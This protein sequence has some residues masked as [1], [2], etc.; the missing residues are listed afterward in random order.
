MVRTRRKANAILKDKE[1]D[2]VMP[3]M[4]V[5]FS[6][7][8]I[9]GV[10]SKSVNIPV[11]PNMK[12]KL[13]PAHPF[14]LNNVGKSGSGKTNV[15]IYML[16]TP[17][18]WRDYFQRVYLFGH[19]VKTDGMYQHL[20]VP[21]KNVFTSDMVD[22][23]DDVISKLEKE[24]KDKGPQHMKRTLIIFEDVSSN[25]DLLRSK[26]FTKC[27][28]QGRHLNMSVIANSHKYKILPRIARLNCK[29]IF[30]FPSTMDENEQIAADWQPAGMTKK[31]F[32]KLIQ[33]A[34]T[35]TKDMPRPFLY[36]NQQADEP[37]RFR[38][39]LSI[40]LKLNTGR[41]PRTSAKRVPDPVEG[42]EN[43]NTR[44]D[45]VSV[46]DPFKTKEEKKPEE[47]EKQPPRLA[48]GRYNWIWKRNAFDKKDGAKTLARK[49]KKPRKRLRN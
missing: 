34:H 42:I 21:K 13:I 32:I 31:D 47:K 23:L 20:N 14:S 22:N 9:Q 38:K 3:E 24:S 4:D 6:G 45:N 12:A 15:L 7:L 18:I 40:M 41:E 35:P 28:V 17:G 36:I 11:N 37:E 30:Y 5:S 25:R 8:N 49:R 48:E 19:T 44:P 26:S 1:A 43:K 39:S 27:Y 29:G 46:E 10:K 16:A 2:D 33:Y